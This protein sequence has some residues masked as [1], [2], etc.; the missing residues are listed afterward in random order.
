MVTLDTTHV[1]RDDM[2]H[3]VAGI[4][5]AALWREDYG[6]VFGREIEHVR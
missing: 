2:T 6:L 5:T 3:V 1:G 4:S